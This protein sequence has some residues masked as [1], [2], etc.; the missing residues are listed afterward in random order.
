MKA[1]KGSKTIDNVNSAIYHEGC[2]DMSIK[3][4]NECSVFDAEAYAIMK[5]LDHIID[6]HQPDHFIIASDSFSVLSALISTK[7]PTRQNHIVQQIKRK[8]S[9]MTEKR[10]QLSCIWIPSHCGIRGNERADELAKNH[11]SVAPVGDVSTEKQRLLNES[12]LNMICA[13][14]TIWENDNKGRFFYLIQP[15]VSLQPQLENFKNLDM[16]SCKIINRIKQDMDVT[17]NA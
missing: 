3:L 15:R 9:K 13:W 1:P 12:N 4:P 7:H 6:E 11:T 14:Q 5:A 16:I 10:Y 2:T 17:N 8:F